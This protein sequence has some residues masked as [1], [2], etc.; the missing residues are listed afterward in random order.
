MD[1]STNLT[2]KRTETISARVYKVYKHSIFPRLDSLRGSTKLKKLLET[3]AK[4]EVSKVDENAA[5][6][7]SD[8]EWENL[9][10]I[11]GCRYDYYR[12]LRKGNVEDRITQGSCSSE[13]IENNF[14]CGGFEDVILVSANLFTSEKWFEKLTGHELE[15]VFY[16]YFNLFNTDWNEDAGTVL[17]CKVREKAELVEKLYPEKKKLIWFLQPHYPFYTVGDTL[18]VNP[19]SDKIEKGTAWE[20]AEKEIYSHDFVV[21]GYR[22]NLKDVISEIDSLKNSL[23]GRTILTSD[24]GN[25]MGENGLYG[26]PYGDKSVYTRRVP[27]EVVQN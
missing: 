15:N 24:H 11:D 16:E 20:K 23:K 19:D 2:A 4:I 3:I 22:E 1:S 13:F 17:P 12:D 6:S 26:H 9:V 27:V 8:Y 18:G 25:Y 21:K 7:I 14:S 10:L 5:S